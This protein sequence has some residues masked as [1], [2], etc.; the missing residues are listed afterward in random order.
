MIFFGILALVAFIFT[1]LVMILIGLNVLFSLSLG[2]LIANLVVIIVA[3][4][5]E[6]CDRY[7]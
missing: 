2:L 5:F 7:K 1:S 3:A 6:A 4:C